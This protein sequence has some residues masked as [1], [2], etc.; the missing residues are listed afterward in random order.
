[1]CCSD[2]ERQ[3]SVKTLLELIQYSN[4]DGNICGNFE[5]IAL[6]VGLQGEHTKYSCFL[7]L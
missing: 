7:S 6:L 2:E 4:H 3:G 1:M 5:M